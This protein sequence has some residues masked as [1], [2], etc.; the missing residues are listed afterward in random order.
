MASIY[1]Y[2]TA[3]D[4]AVGLQGSAVCD[5]AIQAARASATDRD[6]PVVLEDD[7]A[8]TLAREGGPGTTARSATTPAPIRS[9]TRW[10]KRCAPCG[11]ANDG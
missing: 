10:G 2:Q 4:I 11:W 5:E 6:E 8:T 7:G 1:D 9:T 3:H